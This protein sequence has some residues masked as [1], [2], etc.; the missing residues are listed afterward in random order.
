[1]AV[2]GEEGGKKLNK[3]AQL[4]LAAERNNDVLSSDLLVTVEDFKLHRNKNLNQ[5]T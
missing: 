2:L 5:Y 4:K 1:M 3:K